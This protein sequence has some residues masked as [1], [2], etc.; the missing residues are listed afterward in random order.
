MIRRLV[1]AERAYGAIVADCLVHAATEIGGVLPGRTVGDAFVVP[2]SIP[3]GPR[4]KK[5]VVRFSPDS[6]WQQVFLDYLHARFGTDYVGDWHRHPGLYD[7]PSA[8][9]L[10]TA[11]HI[12]TDPDWNKP[13]AVFPIAVIDSGVVRIRA[14]LMRREVLEFQ[15]IPIEIVPDT[16]PRMTAVLTGMD[17]QKEEAAHAEAKARAIGRQPRRNPVRRVLRRMAAGLRHLSRI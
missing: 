16:D 4:A 9:D 11:R 6:G 7:Q 12:V 10:R 5:S 14:Y 15:E 17:A 1:L 3:A 13:E 2:F 8:H